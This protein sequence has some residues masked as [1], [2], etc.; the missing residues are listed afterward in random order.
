MHF[1]RSGAGTRHQGSHS[2][3]DSLNQGSHTGGRYV[4]SGQESGGLICFLHFI[5]FVSL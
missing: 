3:T 5:M 1:L 2:V 4:K